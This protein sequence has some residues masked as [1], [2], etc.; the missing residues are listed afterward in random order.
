MKYCTDRALREKYFRETVA[1]A[2]DGDFDNREN[3]LEI[4]RIQFQI[5]V[6]L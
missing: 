3:A 4:V 6:L 1:I 5:A 2:S